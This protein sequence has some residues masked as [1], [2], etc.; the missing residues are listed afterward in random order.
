M[1]VN[2]KQIN[3]KMVFGEVRKL[4]ISV[5]KRERWDIMFSLCVLIILSI[6]FRLRQS[7]Y[8]VS[9]YRQTSKELD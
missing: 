2:L 8:Y 5:V 6:V 7:Y 9:N 3:W 4:F 1:K